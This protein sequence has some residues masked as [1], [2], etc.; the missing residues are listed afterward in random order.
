MILCPTCDT[1]ISDTEEIQV[2]RTITCSACCT[3][4]EVTSR[5][6]V[7]LKPVEIQPISERVEGD[8]GD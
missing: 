2:S 8:W 7:Q 1:H 6:P 4:L 3:P 5:L